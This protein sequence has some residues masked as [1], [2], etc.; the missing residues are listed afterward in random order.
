M[1]ENIRLDTLGSTAEGEMKQHSTKIKKA[2]KEKKRKIF[3]AAG[4]KQPKISS[5]EGSAL[6]TNIVSSLASWCFKPSQPQRITSGLKETF[7][8]RCI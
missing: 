5:D 8:K 6:R 4:L 3:T 7:I 2:S 1:M